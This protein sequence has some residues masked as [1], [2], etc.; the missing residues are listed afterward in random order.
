MVKQGL[1]VIAVLLTVFIAS[2]ATSNLFIEAG[3]SAEKIYVAFIWHYHQPWYYSPDETHFILP[4]VRM[5]SVGNYYKMAYILSKYPDVKVTFTFSG[6][7]L[8]QIIDYV[9]NGKMDIREIISWKVANNIVTKE[10]VFNMLKMPGGFFDINWARILERSPRYTELRDLARELQRNCSQIAKTSEELVDCVVNGFTQGNLLHQ[11]VVDLAVLFNLLWIDPQVAADKY[12]DI[13][14]LMNKAYSTQQPQFTTEDL[15]K[16]LGIHRD[17]LSQVISIYRDL[18]AKDQIEVIPVPYSHPLAPLITAAGFMEDLEVH[19]K[20]SIDLF[21]NHLGIL[22]RGVWPAEQAVNENVLHAFKKAGVNWTITDSTL[23]RTAGFTTDIE[24]IGIPWYI[25]FVEGKIYV[26][27]RET[28]LSNLISFQY[29]RWDQDQAVNDLVNRILSY[30]TTARGPRIVLIALDGENPWE[31]YPEF[32]TIF[33]NKLYSKLLDL[34][35]QGLL[36]TVTPSDFIESFGYIAKEL[37]QR[38]YKYLDLEGRDIADIPSNS[39][40][41]AYSDLPRKSVLARLPEGSWGGGEVAIWIGQRQENVAWMWFV[42]ARED[43]L[44]S[45]GVS[46]LRELYNKYPDI[47]R[48]LLKAQASDWWWWYGGDGGG[49]P[50]PFDPLF[51]AFLARAYELSGLTP[52]SYLKLTAFPDGTPIGTINQVAPSLVDRELTIDGSIEDTWIDLVGEGKALKVIVGSTVPLAYIGLDTVRLYIALSIQEQSLNELKIAVY[53]ATPGINMTPYNPGYNVYPRGREIDLGIHLARELLINPVAKTV[54]ISKADGRGEWVLLKSYT[55]VS[56]GGSPGNYTLE[57][58]I[59]LTDLELS[60]GQPAYF[61]IVV[62]RG[63]EPIEW[64]SRLG[65]THQIYI[66][67]PPLEEVGTIVLDIEDPVGDDDGVGGLTYPTASVFIS[68]VF[69]LTKFTL[70]DLGDKLVFKFYFRE[71]GGNPWGGPNGWSMQQI[72]VYIKTTI[73]AVGRYD[74]IA[75]NVLIEHGWHIALLIGP[76]WDADPLP[77]GQKTGI[78]YYDKETP[79]I[80]NGGIKPYADPATKAIVVEVSKNILYDIDNIEKWI[81]VVAIT[82]HDGY[83]TNMIRPFA[84]GG[85]EWTVGVPQEYSLA[86]IKKVFPYIIDLLA[87]TK[88][89][90]YSMLRSFDAEQGLLAKIRGIS[91]TPITQT[92]PA[93][94]S[95]PVTTP[96]MPETASSPVVQPPLDS[97]LIGIGVVIAIIVIIIMLILVK[98]GKR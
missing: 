39:Y 33:L 80:Q 73:Q 50:A 34:Q 17:I 26:F 61:V 23:L 76:G 36:E 91:K 29:S 49:S 58:S 16:V 70:V 55:E 71:L 31:N 43:V 93:T 52:P 32:G 78:Y 37:P 20:F 38:Q 79:I 8:E 5:H 24:N 11:N 81:F 12:P 97:W 9:E 41:D 72:H 35:S 1:K 74:A 62:Y 53:F 3:N 65:L 83:G 44:N 28:E 22:P 51:K 86:I 19:V 56:V 47:A 27:F 88:E 85:G 69:D 25:D 6:S 63:T 89:E 77:K 75:L 64:S 94:T 54:E 46:G 10:D 82:S 98:K 42:K 90:Q 13:Y 21:E 60:T 59:K 95:P 15:V 87:P 2:W 92:P 7:L 57:T 14:L 40:G 45:L 4:W 84:V 67:T 48:Y 66:P 96:T 18:V 68:G 30:R